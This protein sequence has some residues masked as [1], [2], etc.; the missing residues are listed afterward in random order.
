M[1]NLR[2]TT[3]VQF[4]QQANYLRTKAM[5]LP[6]AELRSKVFESA[7]CLEELAREEERKAE[8]VASAPFGL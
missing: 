7:N 1:Y 2:P 6:G 8:Q 5:Q 4:R 3:A